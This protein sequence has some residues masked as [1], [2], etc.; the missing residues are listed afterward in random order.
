M[1]VTTYPYISVC[2][3]RFRWHCSVTMNE[4]III[5]QTRK[6]GWQALQNLIRI[7]HWK[8]Y[9]GWNI[10]CPL[11]L[12]EWTREMDGYDKRY[13][14]ATQKQST[15]TYIYGERATRP[16]HNMHEEVWLK[17]ETREKKLMNWNCLLS[18]FSFCIHLS[19]TAGSL[20]TLFRLHRHPYAVARHTTIITFLIC[21]YSISIVISCSSA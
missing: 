20:F 6:E 13:K 10:F 1:S 4:Y 14:H 17:T 12:E 21:D 11:K 7:V 18:Q 2:R 9:M 5:W 15:H 3:S 8:W 16:V 19:S